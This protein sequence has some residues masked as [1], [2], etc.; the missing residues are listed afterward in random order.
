MMIW[1][2][3]LLDNGTLTDLT[4]GENKP[5]LDRE[6]IGHLTVYRVFQ[7]L[8]SGCGPWLAL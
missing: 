5:Q 3:G 1:F 7:P 6:F 2:L 8:K 4:G